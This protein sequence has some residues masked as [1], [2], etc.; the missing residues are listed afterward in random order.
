MRIFGDSKIEVC[1]ILMG[2]TF[3][4]E[5]TQRHTPAL[6]LIKSTPFSFLTVIQNVIKFTEKGHRFE[7]TKFLTDSEGLSSDSDK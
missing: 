1:M 7:D 4:L 6:S 5:L 3:I 2:R